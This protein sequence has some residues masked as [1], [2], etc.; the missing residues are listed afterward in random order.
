MKRCVTELLARKNSVAVEYRCCVGYAE[1]A[2]EHKTNNQRR[3]SVAA[4]RVL[5]RCI[6]ESP[7]TPDIPA[8]LCNIFGDA[9][10]VHRKGM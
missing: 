10:A 1:G 3:K 5:E 6:T 8:K 4:R 7:K 9:E 2:E